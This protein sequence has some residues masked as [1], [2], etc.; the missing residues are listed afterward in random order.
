MKETH[1]SQDIEVITGRKIIVTSGKG[2]TNVND[3]TWVAEQVNS[4]ADNFAGKT[5]VFTG[6][7][8]QLTR[9]EAKALGT[10]LGA[11]VAGSVSNNTDY[12]IAGTNAGSKLKKAQEFGIEILSEEEFLNKI[13]N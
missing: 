12:V 1:G 3:L 13:N 5:I 4:G 6:T 10:K 9:A 8:E 11:K 7:L 2:K